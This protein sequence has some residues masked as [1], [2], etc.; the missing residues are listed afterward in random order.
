MIIDL[1]RMSFALP[2]V[3]ILE[4]RKMCEKAI[5]AEQVSLRDVASILG[6]FTWAR[7]TPSPLV[8]HSLVETLVIVAGL[9]WPASLEN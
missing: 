5:T 7:P 2:P 1:V 6:N 3:K 4:V 9:S 8:S